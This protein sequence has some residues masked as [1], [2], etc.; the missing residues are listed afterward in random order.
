MI[1]ALLLGEDTKSLLRVKAPLTVPVLECML[2]SMA[3]RLLVPRAMPRFSAPSGTTGART[4]TVTLAGK[5][6][7]TLG[8]AQ[9]GKPKKVR[10]QKLLK[11]VETE[12][13]IFYTVVL[14]GPTE[15]VLSW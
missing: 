6:D 4:L 11:T 15:I 8:L 2:V 7:T 3:P 5:G 1:S 13:R 14:N 12:D 10:T 9:G